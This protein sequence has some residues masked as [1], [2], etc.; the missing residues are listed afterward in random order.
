MI[1]VAILVVGHSRNK[2]TA[3]LDLTSKILTKNDKYKYHF[4]FQLWDNDYTY[5]NYDRF[6]SFYEKIDIIEKEPLNTLSSPYPH[7]L[8]KTKM[9]DILS[10]TYDMPCSV[11]NWHPFFLKSENDF[12]EENALLDMYIYTR[13]LHKFSQWYSIQR[14]YETSQ[15]HQQK[16]NLKFDIFIKTRYD[17]IF[18]EQFDLALEKH[19]ELLLSSDSPLYISAGY[20]RMINK[21][22][23]VSDFKNANSILDTVGISNSSCA[24]KLYSNILLDAKKICMNQEN[25]YQEECVLY[26]ICA[27]N[28]IN[29]HES[30]NSIPCAILR[31]E[32]NPT[33]L[34]QLNATMKNIYQRQ[35][36]HLRSD[37]MKK[38][39]HYETVLRNI[40]SPGSLS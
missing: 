21:S 31:S 24:E 27:M 33:A 6:K 39:S 38:L 40:Q 19:V 36:E 14:L 25:L 16:N 28:G 32:D 37:T 9:N 12:D 5:V 8:I 22:F 23:S 10:L 11:D 1:N 2:E 30:Q 35:E 7:T 15:E 20:G 4:F 18:E 17:V 26:D 13:K 29:I 3:F 34:S